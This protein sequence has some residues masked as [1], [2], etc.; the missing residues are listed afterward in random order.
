MHA[1]ETPALL[2]NL[3]GPAIHVLP[4]RARRD[5]FDGIDLH[6]SDE[7]A[8]KTRNSP[9]MLTMNDVNTQR[10]LIGDYYHEFRLKIN[11]LKLFVEV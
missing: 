1:H 3:N 4:R 9:A 6:S 11:R 8:K 10:A 5:D 2:A 7:W